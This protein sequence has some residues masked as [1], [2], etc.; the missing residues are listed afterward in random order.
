M[1]VEFWLVGCSLV[2]WSRRGTGREEQYQR[3]QQAPSQTERTSRQCRGRS[4]RE[5]EETVEPEHAGTLS[6][7][8]QP[9]ARASE[10]SARG[11]SVACA[12]RCGGALRKRMRVR[13]R[14]VR[15]RV[16]RFPRAAHAAGSK[17]SR[18]I[19]REGCLPHAQWPTRWLRVGIRVCGPTALSCRSFVELKF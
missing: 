2:G 9:P 14:L 16:H 15:S 1:R 10:N 5:H 19:K 4:R 12:R 3:R 17:S 7:R 11:W 13:G 6:S 18:F 8:N